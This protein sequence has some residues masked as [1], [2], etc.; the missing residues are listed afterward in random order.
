MTANAFLTADALEKAFRE[1][2]LKA[3]AAEVTT[4]EQAFAIVSR[5]YPALPCRL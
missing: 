5:Y 3:R 4:A 1:L 2:G